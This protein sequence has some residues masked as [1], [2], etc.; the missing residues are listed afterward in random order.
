MEVSLVSGAFWSVITA[1]PPATVEPHISRK[2]RAIHKTAIRFFP[3]PPTADPFEKR[4]ARAIRA[5]LGAE[6]PTEHD[7]GLGAQIARSSPFAAPPR[8]GRP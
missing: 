1:A 6:Q 4:S 7:A 5:A 2:L 8:G 3:E